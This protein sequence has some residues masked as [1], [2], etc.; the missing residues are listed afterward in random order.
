VFEE[1][2]LRMSS[3]SESDVRCKNGGIVMGSSSV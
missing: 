1:K 2:N 3:A